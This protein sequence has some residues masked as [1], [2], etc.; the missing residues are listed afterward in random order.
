M[1]MACARADR[2][3]GPYEVN[4]EIS[5]DE[6]FGLPLG[7]RPR[8]SA[9]PFVVSP[10]DPAARGR[11][12]MH[13]GGI[14]DTP[15]G[16]WW[17]LSMM[18]ANSIGRLTAL[19]PVTWKDG[20]PYFGL[21]GNLERTPRIWVKPRTAFPAAPTAPYRR[22]DDFSGPVLANVWQWNHVPDDGRW[23]LAERPGFLRLHSLPAPDFWRARNTLTQRAI[24]PQSA[25]TTVLE[26]RGMRPGD[27]AGLA[28][29]NFPYAWIGVRRDSGGFTLEQFDQTTGRAVRRALRVGRVWLR[30]ECDFLTEKARFSYSVDGRRFDSLGGEFTMIF[31]LTTF[32]GV[33]YA[34]FHYN[35]G[36]SAGGYADFDQMT[37][38]EPHPRALTRPVPVGRTIALVTAGG[39][40]V[41]AASG[42]GLRGVRPSGGGAFPAAARFRVVDRGLGRV[43]LGAAGGFVSVHTAASSRVVV[44]AGRPADAET[45]QWIETPS[46][47]LA[48]LSLATHRYL[49]IDAS[50]GTVAADQ[51][52]PLPD[53]SGGVTFHWRL[54][55]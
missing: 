43:A 15:E 18:D 53:R 36:G 51:A 52:G 47:D 49:R 11:L 26:T 21:P 7:Y 41:L 42:D 44:K 37:V 32:Q 8:G 17:G 33:R 1:R 6:D 54:V 50:S 29:L 22:D 3:E 10:P 48:L 39:G 45:F 5:A 4:P 55:P 16:E 13:Q 19:S 38:R 14:V 25:P 31:Q 30:A 27:V 9:P 12:S 2:P 23:S 40:S 35:D 46:G 20:W 34:L 24:G 28:L